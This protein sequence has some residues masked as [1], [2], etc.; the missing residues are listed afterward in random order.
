MK[1]QYFES[2]AC[3]SDDEVYRYTL[4][5]Y[6]GDRGRTHDT[7]N[8]CVFIGLNPSTADAIKDDPTIR[9]CIGFADGFRKSR[10]LMLNAY[11][12]RST[13]PKALL[14]ATDPVGPMNDFFL[15]SQHS[16]HLLIAAW[17]SHCPIERELELA[18]IFKDHQ[19]MCLG[20]NSDG[21]PRHPLYIPS[22]QHLIPYTWRVK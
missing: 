7:K 6:W 14:R 1:E 16:D 13:N 21:T 17:G 18:D 20:T 8:V 12:F 10:L 3:I 15:G 19:L 5:R 4:S 2:A 22:S 11:A 9:R